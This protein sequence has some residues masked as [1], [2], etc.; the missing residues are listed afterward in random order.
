MPKYSADGRLDYS[1]IQLGLPEVT[2]EIVME[3]NSN[4]TAQKAYWLAQTELCVRI[5]ATGS[6][7]VG[8]G[9][10]ST[11]TMIIDM[12]GKWESF[13]GLDDQ[14][15]NDI[16]TGTFRSRYSNTTTATSTQFTKFL[17]VNEVATLP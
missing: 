3:H 1:F 12:V 15:G 10:Y 2:A 7:T 9:A 14:D 16:V 4:A 6:A 17:V 5:I 8:A 13:S 11:K